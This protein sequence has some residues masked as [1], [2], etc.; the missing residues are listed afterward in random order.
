MSN[1]AKRPAAGTVN[2]IDSVVFDSAGKLCYGPA[3]DAV[4]SHVPTGTIFLTGSLI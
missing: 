1:I 3:I 2:P 4:P